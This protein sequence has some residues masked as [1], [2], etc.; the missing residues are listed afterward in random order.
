VTTSLETLAA[1]DFS[2]DVRADNGL[3]FDAT[4]LCRHCDA[5][6]GQPVNGPDWVHLNTGTRACES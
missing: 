2:E 4:A 1:P 3:S 6:I 5:V